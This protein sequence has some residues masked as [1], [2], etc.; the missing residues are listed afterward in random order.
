[1]PR[2]GRSDG[3]VVSCPCLMPLPAIT[4]PS[5]IV[6]PDCSEASSALRCDAPEQM[7]ASP[8]VFDSVEVAWVSIVSAF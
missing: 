8:S 6:T 1:M 4:F 3:L 7:E 5:S 2:E